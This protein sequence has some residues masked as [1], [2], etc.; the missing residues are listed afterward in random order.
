MALRDSAAETPGLAPRPTKPASSHARSSREI[1]ADRSA[2]EELTGGGTRSGAGPA[3]GCSASIH[4]RGPPGGRARGRRA[5]EAGAEPGQRDR[6]TRR[7]PAGLRAARG[8]VAGPRPGPPRSP[9]S[10]VKPPPASSP[11]TTSLNYN[12]I[13]GPDG[14]PEEDGCGSG[15][16]RGPPVV[17]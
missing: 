3:A 15:L 8:R 1:G 12:A 14:T 4:E 17:R 2:G 5:R 16:T 9:D 13:G 6:P 7:A 11:T 10:R